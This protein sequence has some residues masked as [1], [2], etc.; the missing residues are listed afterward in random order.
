MLL[1]GARIK[2]IQQKTKKWQ[3]CWNKKS[4]LSFHLLV[5]TLLHVVAPKGTIVFWLLK[6]PLIFS[7]LTHGVLVR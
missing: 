3:Q 1:L 2:R 7:A 5:I 4:G 6:K